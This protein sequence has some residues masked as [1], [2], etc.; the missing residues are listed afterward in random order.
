MMMVVVLIVVPEKMTTM[1]LQSSYEYDYF[2]VQL[3]GVLA[4]AKNHLP[5]VEMAVGVK[6][7]RSCKEMEAMGSKSLL[8]GGTMSLALTSPGR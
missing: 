6:M 5:R 8:Y 3:C 7:I 4:P 2:H 1:M